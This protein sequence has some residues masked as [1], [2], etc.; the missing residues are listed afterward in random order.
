MTERVQLALTARVVAQVVVCLKSAGFAPV[1]VMPEKL[2]AALPVLVRV[3]TL[4]A[5]VCATMVLGKESEVTD[6]RSLGAEAAEAP[7]AP[8]S[9][10]IEYARNLAFT[11]HLTAND[12]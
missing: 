4:A 8:A 6:K 7:A 12:I 2:S 9:S 11:E 3:T 10:R 5:L 1:I